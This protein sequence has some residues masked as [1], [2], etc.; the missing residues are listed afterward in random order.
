MSN[1]AIKHTHTLKVLRQKEYAREKN[2]HMLYTQR[3]QV[4]IYMY[5][6]MR[7]KENR[8]QDFTERGLKT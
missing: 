7:E 3:W 2:W 5:K 4:Y 8:E 1:E 6:G